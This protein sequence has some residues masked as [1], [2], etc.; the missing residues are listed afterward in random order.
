MFKVK[1]VFKFF[2]CYYFSLQLFGLSRKK[3]V[4]RIK[5]PWLSN[6]LKKTIISLINFKAYVFF[7]ERLT[8]EKKTICDQ[9]SQPVEN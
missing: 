2:F 4:L 8:R 9:K 3:C 5:K 1:I 6:V 7:L